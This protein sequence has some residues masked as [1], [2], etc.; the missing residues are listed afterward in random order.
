MQLSDKGLLVIIVHSKGAARQ[1]SSLLRLKT[2]V[3][4]FSQQFGRHEATLLPEMLGLQA[5]K[6]QNSGPSENVWHRNWCIQVVHLI[7]QGNREVA[8][9]RS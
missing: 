3:V 1:C 4:R 5:V 2:D 6:G 7:R 8:G 9:C